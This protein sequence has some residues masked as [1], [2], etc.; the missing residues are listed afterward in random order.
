[1]NQGENREMSTKEP[2]STSRSVDSSLLQ[3]DALLRAV[4]AIAVFP[5]LYLS[6]PVNLPD[7]KSSFGY[8]VL[9]GVCYALMMLLPAYHGKWHG[10][11]WLH[12]ASVMDNLFISM[13]LI[14]GGSSAAPLFL[15]YLL[16][17]A[18][19]S[20]AK[21]R[22]LIV[23]TGVLSLA[24]LSISIL[25]DHSGELGIF[26]STLAG[27]LVLASLFAWRHQSTAAQSF[28]ATQEDSDP[29]A[30]VGTD[31]LAVD[32][33]LQISTELIDSKVLYLSNDS[34]DRHGVMRHLASWGINRHRESNTIRAFTALINAVE[35]SKPF[36]AVLVDQK[37]MD[38]D[39]VQFASSVRAET[40][41]QSLC[42]IYIGPLTSESS[43][44]RL[45]NAG[46]SKLI[47]TPVDK[48]LLYKA[49]HRSAE[50]PVSDPGVVNLF[51]HY[52]AQK[53]HQPLDILFA[54]NNIQLQHR[55]KRIL[56]RAGH[57]LYQV[58]NGN[59]VL[60]A[61]E[62]HHFDIAL[63][64]QDI[65]ETGGLQALKLYRFTRLDQPWIPF[66]LVLDK[67]TTG[68]IQKCEDAGVDA[69]ISLPIDQAWLLDTLDTLAQNKE[70]DV[71]PQA[72]SSLNTTG[73]GAVL[74][75]D[76]L[77]ALETLSED[78]QFL[79]NLID[80][81]FND[82]ETIITEMA[83]AIET[84]KPKVFR[85]LGHSLRDIT[86]NMGTLDIYH[87]SLK[88]A[89]LRDSD[90]PEEAL[91]LLSDINTAR[92]IAREALQTHV[93]KRHNSATE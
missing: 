81:F 43:E 39:P 92:K 72:P 67:P 61:L 82:C 25:T 41:L 9:A 27:L 86:G 17:L 71:L 80:H 23:V 22:P 74:D 83:L 75:D 68:M 15:G 5:A 45:H 14:T 60:D 28:K 78:Q 31:G 66:V 47:A 18:Q 73:S 24:G 65:P 76:R 53:R 55:L 1:M 87:L 46:Y 29:A 4:I 49:L 51:D 3:R 59:Q 38:M 89:R 8:V 16:L 85:N 64:E 20:Y 88:A 62:S 40:A 42:L 7:E 54:A 91:Q 21:S 90:F 32:E 50:L 44:Q 69:Y 77:Q 56:E 57:R 79:P 2:Q 84:R 36:H 12:A 58:T 70:N 52:P 30:E 19:S 93:S 33:S 34:A 10:K 13:G 63:V 37:H 11:G 35:Q 6:F 26:A 48:S